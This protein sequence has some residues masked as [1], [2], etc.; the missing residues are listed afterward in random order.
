MS[1]VASTNSSISERFSKAFFALE[2]V[3]D[4]FGRECQASYNCLGDGAFG[5][6]F[7]QAA[8]VA[9]HRVYTGGIKLQLQRVVAA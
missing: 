2:Y 8:E 7:G 6:F 1:S 9:C 5:G 3:G 4:A